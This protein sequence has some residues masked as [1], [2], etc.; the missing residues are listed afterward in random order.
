MHVRVRREPFL[1]YVSQN[2]PTPSLKSR[3]REREDRL[4]FFTLTRLQSSLRYE[5][6]IQVTVVSLPFQ[7]SPWDSDSLS[8]T[9]PSVLFTHF[10]LLSLFVVVAF[11]GL[12]YYYPLLFLLH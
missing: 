8:K 9:F 10:G 4:F 11:P 7:L 5:Q 6:A 12:K 3:R 2:P 1:Y